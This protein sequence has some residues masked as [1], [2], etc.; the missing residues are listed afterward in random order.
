VA[1]ASWTLCIDFGT[2]YSKA[3]AAPADAWTRFDPRTVRPLMIAEGEGGANPYL[4]ESAVFVEEDRILFGPAAVR[5]ANARPKRMALKSFKTLLSVSDLDR[6]LNTGVPASI[7]PHRIFTMGDLISLYL[8]YLGAT[9]ERGVAADAMVSGE[10]VF[11]R[12][13]AAPAW[14]SGDSAGLHGLVSRLFGQSEALRVVRGLDFLAPEGISID[15]AR[16]AIDAARSGF[17]AANLGLVFEATAAGAFTSVGLSSQAPALIIADMGAGTTDFAVLARA[18]SR[19]EELADAR[20]TL[21]QAGDYIDGVIANLAIAAN[22]KLKE[23]SEQGALWRVAMASMRDLKEDLFQDSQAALRHD[24]RT[25][26]I[27]MRALERA[28][29]F[30]AFQSAIEYAYDRSLEI[31]CDYAALH[32]RREILTVAVGGGAAAPFIKTLLT[33]KPKRGGKFLIT[34]RPATPDWAHAREFGGNLAPVFPQLA[35]AVGGAIAPASMLA[36]RPDRV[37]QA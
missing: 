26:M 35:I 6:A 32:G 5:A 31:A 7:D 17:P 18:G 9:I 12:R 25:T 22:A 3:A 11:E 21:K 16:S 36:A 34:P 29:D 33:R 15:A 30:R 8:A 27:K 19:V 4:L 28:E 37:S 20:I 14:R 13:Y 1:D 10:R 23:Q 24:G 2:A